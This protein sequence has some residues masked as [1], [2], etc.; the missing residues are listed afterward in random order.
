MRFADPWALL[1]LTS[2][3]LYLWLQWPRRGRGPGAYLTVPRLD[4]L[5]DVASL[6][7]ARW[8][9]LPPALRA[10]ALALT[11]VALARPQS[12]SDAR[13]VTLHGRNLMLAL[14]ISS[15]MRAVDFGPGGNRLAVAKRA[16][17]D[18]V[19]R[20][21]GDLMGLVIF[22]GAAFTQAPLSL[23]GDV[24]LRLIDR[25]DL[26]MLRDG[27]A[28]GTALT[29]C[30]AHLEDLPA[31]N[32]AV[33]LITDGIN[34]AGE[35]DPLTAAGIA[36][37][38]GIRVYTIGVSSSS[39]PA[40]TTPGWHSNQRSTRA[41]GE[42]AA[43]PTDLDEGVLRAM[44]TAT[45]GEYFWAHD[46]TSLDRIL[47]T[48]DRLERGTIRYHE[49]LRYRELFGWLVAAALGLLAIEIGLRLRRLGTLP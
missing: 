3:P 1:L 7:S 39:M 20:R 12:A 2:V 15:S 23:N 31:K 41:F 13:D 38:L 33:V 21:H 14:D 34:N 4:L 32:S 36:R 30:L 25:V 22:S 19:A 8:A 40:D 26:G 29:M 46:A 11:V 5:Q 17:S 27:T 44:A 37:A 45:G 47:R 16:L 35:P 18:F 6:G 9:R 42:L 48:I 43:T 10:G 24:L 28:I 49:V